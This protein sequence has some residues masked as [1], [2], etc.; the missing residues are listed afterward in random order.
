MIWPP[1][2]VKMRATSRCA[3]SACSTIAAAVF[4]ER[5]DAKATPRRL[6]MDL[7]LAGRVAIV[8]GGSRGI[9]RAIA[10]E[11]ASEGVDVAIAS[12]TAEALEHT[13]AELAEATGRR[14][15]PL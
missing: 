2:S 13:A 4:T 11:L 7:G 5:S 14:I 15:L 1:A 10:R 9:G 3:R 6:P 8:T 12:R